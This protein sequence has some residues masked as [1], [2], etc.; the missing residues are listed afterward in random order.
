MRQI[1]LLILG[2]VSLSSYGQDQELDQVIIDS[3]YREDQI[4]VGVTFNLLGDR[5][6]GVEQNSFSGGLQIG[7]LRDMPIN[8]RRNK[9]IALGLGWSFDSYSSNLFIGERA[10]ES[11]IYDVVSSEDDAS[12]N[13]F[14]MYQIEMPL[15]FRWRT[16]TAQ[17]YK[18]WRV[19]V[20]AKLGYIYR[21]K[22]RFEQPGNKV[23]QT[24]LDELN[25]LQYGATLSFGYGA[26]NLKA[27]YGLNT[28]FNSNAKLIATNNGVDLQLIRLGVQ[29]YFL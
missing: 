26:F 9:S 25:T 16:S 1:L 7:F 2:I 10:D 4:Y 29:F 13:R 12:I 8:K 11:S 24:S 15:E 18:F 20:G 22:S 21:F 23:N 17:T 27:Y 14:V 3:L 19:H 5:P 28:I 6:A